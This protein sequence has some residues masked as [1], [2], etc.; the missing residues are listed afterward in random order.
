MKKL[1][2]ILLAVGLGGIV[3]SGCQK[4]AVAS[5]GSASDSTSNA[6]S[7]VPTTGSLLI[8]GGK[9]DYQ[10]VLPEGAE[11]NLSF[12]ANELQGFLA[13]SS[14]V[15]LPI[16]TDSLVSFGA[17]SHYLSLG[18]T[19][20]FTASGLTLDSSLG[21]T[22][23]IA[24]RVDKSLI[25]NAKNANGVISAVYDVLKYTINLEIYANDEMDF[26]TMND[27]PLLDFDYS[28]IPLVDVREML[29]KV[30]QNNATYNRRMKL[31]QAKGAG[32]W[33]AFGH[34]VISVFLPLK[35]YQ[36]AHPDWYN[37]AGTQICY[38]NEEMFKEMVSRVEKQ[39]D[40]CPDAMYIQLGHE[41]NHDM[42]ECEACVAARKKFGN[43][44]GQELDFLNR[45]EAAVDPWFKAKYPTRTMRYVF[46]GYVTSAQ[47]PVTYDEVTDTF[48]PLYA[49]VKVN[50]NVM[51]MYCPIEMDFSKKMTDPANA[52]QY[53]QLKGW[54]Y[55]FKK[56]GIDDGLYIWTY[57]LLCYGTF[58]PMNNFG[59]YGENYKTMVDLG[60][61]CI[62]DQACYQSA[63]PCFEA[64]KIYTQSQLM[65]N[66]KLD[67]NTIAEDF[68][69]HYYGEAS[70]DV[71]AFYHYLRSY[72]KYLQDEKALGGG[73][74]TV[75]YD[76][77]FWPLDVLYD[78]MAFLE[79]GIQD[80]SSIKL[81]K[82]ERYQTLYDRLRREEL[83]PI[84]LMLT[85]YIDS[86]PQ[87]EK[88]EYWHILKDYVAKYNITITAESKFDIDETIENWRVAI[89]GDNA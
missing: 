58:V 87:V 34:T 22:G 55:L 39:I 5:S 25:L 72:Y 13:E 28:Y 51:V 41:D 53:Q 8:S 18:P 67:Y 75:V 24:K 66:A 35:T 86:L 63:L 62:M 2:K 78:F 85:F 73:I 82:P 50:P 12:A 4:Q 31:F 89:F 17:D 70:K 76:Q 15:T 47:P 56:S 7:S 83:F 11:D 44:G 38:S 52:T 36:A 88:E 19:S 20:I 43:Y 48:T 21:E 79:K 23:Y 84:Y 32:K 40:A 1:G 77:K 69:A 61:R 16:I 33:A 6:P 54:S 42:C 27:V 10:I 29:Y 68:I 80:L 65:Y 64:F 3:L 57:S 46:F 9:S 45:I 74:M 71:D 60:C 14:G 26:T 30:V 37:A 81:S 59:V 49:E